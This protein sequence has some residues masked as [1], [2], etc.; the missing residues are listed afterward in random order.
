[1]L[2]KCFRKS[3][4]TKKNYRTSNIKFNLGFEPGYTSN[5]HVL[6]HQVSE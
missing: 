3:F 2:P 1:M 4:F 6:K 5:N